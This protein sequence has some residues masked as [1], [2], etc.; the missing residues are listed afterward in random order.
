MAAEWSP[1]EVYEAYYYLRLQYLCEGPR[2]G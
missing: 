1:D 2:T